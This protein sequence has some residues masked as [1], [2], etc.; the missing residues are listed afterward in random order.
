MLALAWEG[1]VNLLDSRK[2]FGG[3]EPPPAQASAELHQTREQ[4]RLKFI[5]ESGGPLDK[6]RSSEFHGR[7]VHQGNLPHGARH[8]GTLLGFGHAPRLG[9]KRNASV[10]L[11]ESSYRL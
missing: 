1:A 8:C 4:N 2:N 5:V 11:V 7:H 3:A 10:L 9:E 6:V